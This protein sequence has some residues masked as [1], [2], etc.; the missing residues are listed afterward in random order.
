MPLSRKILVWS[1]QF[2]LSLVTGFYAFSVA[3]AEPAR[4]ALLSE[5]VNKV[6]LP[7]AQQAWD[8]ALV[9]QR[10]NAAAQLIIGMGHGAKLSDAWQ[11]GNPH[12]ERAHARMSRSI[13]EEEARSG[14]LFMVRKTDFLASFMPPWNDEEL[15]SLI[16]IA[17]TDFGRSYVRLLDLMLTPVFVKQFASMKEISPATVTKLRQVE[18]LAKKEFAPLMLQMIA[19][20]KVNGDVANR[21]KELVSRI[22]HA[23]GYKLGQSLMMPS[24]TRLLNAMYVCM[25]DLLEIIEDHRNTTGNTANRL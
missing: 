22:S 6:D 19:L 15:K 17:D 18:E 10:E 20:E 11:R 9:D 4:Q 7:Y 8:L 3:G 1:L 2:V 12:W 16:Q 14:P 21:V 24:I 13:A 23:E 5:L 25:Q